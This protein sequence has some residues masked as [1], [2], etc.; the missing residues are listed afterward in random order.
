VL[1]ILLKVK[2]GLGEGHDWVECGACGAGWQVPYYAEA[3]GA[4]A[5]T[6]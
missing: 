1:K 3:S 6:G 4:R 5:R 2:P